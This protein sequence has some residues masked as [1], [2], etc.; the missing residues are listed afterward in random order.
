MSC[1]LAALLIQVRV[2]ITFCQLYLNILSLPSFFLH[3]QP[4][5]TTKTHSFVFYNRGSSRY[6]PAVHVQLPG[7]SNKVVKMNALKG[8]LV[9]TK[10]PKKDEPSN[11]IVVTPPIELTVTPPEGSIISSP[12]PSQP[13]S[14]PS[15]LFP[16]GD[17]RNL[18]RESVLDV[19]ADVMVS[20]LHQQQLEKLWAFG[21]PSE[22]VVLKKA[23]DN[24]TCCPATLRDEAN[25]FFDNVVAMNVRVSPQFLNSHCEFC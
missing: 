2:S 11:Q 19:K 15:S 4:T 20:W 12:G 21:I 10:K 3:V 9:P 25:G 1:G 24:F 8:Y 6:I 23:R 5:S 7:I 22:G 13:P 17:F 14:R 16:S 18:P